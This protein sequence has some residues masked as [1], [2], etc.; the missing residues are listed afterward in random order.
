MPGS[1]RTQHAT[2]RLVSEFDSPWK[3]ALDL[4]F[5]PFLQFCFPNIHQG[6][7]WLRGY[8]S[9]DKELQKIVR[10][11]ET[12][13]RV[14]DKLIRVWR[15][16]GDEQWILVHVEVQSQTQ[17]EFPRRMFVYYYRLLDRYNRGVASLAVLGD[18]E[19]GW[20]PR[21][22]TH[23]LF[24]CGVE[25]HFPTVK[26]LDY[27]DQTDGLEGSGNPFATLVLVHL[28]AQETRG[29]PSSRFV[30][31]LRLVRALYE[32]GLSAEEVRNLFR[33]IDWM[34]DLP[35]ELEKKFS[36]E[37]HQFE[38]EK[39]MPYVTSIERLAHEEGIEKGIQEGRQEGVVR[40]LLEGIAS[41]LEIRFDQVPEPIMR[42]I[43]QLTDAELL[44]KVLQQAKAVDRPEQLRTL[45]MEKPDN[46]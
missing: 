16:S 23:E 21:R 32:R 20:R 5:E 44:R 30:W 28:K 33:F 40:G 35:T 9:L 34:M 41:V 22:Y 38:K 3:E 4:Y 6:I 10:Q 2:G 39:H 46:G 19:P 27:A 42:E 36:E 26:L 31:K 1:V 24:G 8:E 25:F 45:W 13:R 15:A 17:A 18:E 29:N 43:R 7:N 11:S 12:G 37:L 14:V